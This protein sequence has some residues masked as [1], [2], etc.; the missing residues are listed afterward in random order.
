MF[1]LELLWHQDDYE[2]C[3]SLGLKDRLHTPFKKALSKG[4]RNM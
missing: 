4:Q 3:N 2:V 1:L